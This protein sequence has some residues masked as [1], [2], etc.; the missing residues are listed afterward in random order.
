[1]TA[2][3]VLSAARLTFTLDDAR[4]DDTAGGL[5]QLVGVPADSGEYDDLL[6]DR[7]RLDV[8][9]RRLSAERNVP[10]V[11]AIAL[12]EQTWRL[13]ADTAQ[14]ASL[15]PVVH[16][17]ERFVAPIQLTADGPVSRIAIAK[18]GT[19]THGDYGTFTIDVDTVAE[20]AANLKKLPGKKA[21]VDF[22]HS[23]DRSPRS[24]AAAGWITSL[25]LVGD[26]PTATVTWTTAGA[27]A[28]ESG[29][30]QFFSPTFGQW[31]DENGMKHANVLSGGALTNRPFLNMPS[32]HLDGR[33]R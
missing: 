23:A 15:P 1:V 14:T 17:G 31:S 10:Y 20:W 27:Q 29:G 32:V 3:E 13:A 18:L 24:T 19:F 22:D 33:G 26:V 30:Y 6:A 25:E 16:D 8:V 21:L 4:G 28:V 2:D 12:F 11:D 7:D 5:A 9:L